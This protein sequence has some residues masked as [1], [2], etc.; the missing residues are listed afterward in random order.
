MVIIVMF[1]LWLWIAYVC[2][3][4]TCLSSCSVFSAF[5][6]SNA[7]V[8][9]WHGVDCSINCPSGSWGL[10]CNLTCACSNGGAC[11]ALDG[12]C[13]CTPGWRGDRCDQHCQVCDSSQRNIKPCTVLMFSYTCL[14]C[15]LLIFFCIHYNN[16]EPVLYITSQLFSIFLAF[17]HKA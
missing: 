1:R 16:T 12:R 2:V 17:T 7:V 4:F 13:T 11:D 6:I 5:M 8:S 10:G 14:L 15:H 9:G 3:L